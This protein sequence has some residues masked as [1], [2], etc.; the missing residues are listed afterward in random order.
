MA[1]K[2]KENPAELCIRHPGP[3]Q[4]FPRCHLQVSLGPPAGAH[5]NGWALTWLYLRLP[6]T[7]RLECLPGTLTI[8]P[9][10]QDPDPGASLQPLVKPLGAFQTNFLK[11][12]C[13]CPTR[14]K[15]FAPFPETQTLREKIQVQGCHSGCLLRHC[16]SYFW[17]CSLE[18]SLSTSPKIPQ[19]NTC[20]YD[21]L[22]PTL[23]SQ[24]YN[25]QILTLDRLS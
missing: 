1:P 11:G 15:K 21:T 19:S 5:L 7:L 12:G 24:N 23:F 10:Y 8:Y 25:T 4:E 22:F 17:P 2:I 14:S 6:F 18:T 20:N 16:I 13:C 3:C 9:L